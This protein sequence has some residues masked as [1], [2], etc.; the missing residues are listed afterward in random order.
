[1]VS[2]LLRIFLF[3]FVLLFALFLEGMNLLFFLKNAVLFICCLGFFGMIFLGFSWEE[4]KNGLKSAYCDLQSSV[5]LHLALY[6]WKCMIRNILLISL[7]PMFYFS[8]LI[9][10]SIDQPFDEICSLL[11]AD[12]VS[13][14][15]AMILILVIAIPAI[16][17]IKQEIA[18]GCSNFQID[19]SVSSW[20]FNK[21]IGYTCFFIMMLLFGAVG[22]N[23]NILIQ[24][25]ELLMILGGTWAIVSTT[26]RKKTGRKTECFISM[27]IKQ[28]RTMADIF[29]GLSM[30]SFVNSG[31]YR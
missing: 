5:D 20:K 26:F 14:A 17:Q 2:F 24:P 18:K 11:A 29:D 21:L 10:G 31:C 6:F 16:F 28:F 19:P 8:I 15:V 25:I 23:V 3:L 27:A 7:I 13:L 30:W 22:G 1:M 12:T 4:I 9:G